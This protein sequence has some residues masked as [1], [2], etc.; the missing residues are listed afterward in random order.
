MALHSQHL[1]R[2]AFPMAPTHKAPPGKPSFQRKLVKRPP[3]KGM[4]AKI[5]AIRAAVGP[6]LFINA[7]T[8]VY[9]R[10]LAP[11]GERRYRHE[12]ADCRHGPGRCG[13]DQAFR[14]R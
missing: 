2:K 5:A 3:S 1:N 7:R 12:C 13:P 14:F 8:D 10:G 9:L 11:V 6:D 4:A